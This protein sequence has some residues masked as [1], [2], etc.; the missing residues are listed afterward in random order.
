MSNGLLSVSDII[1]KIQ[2]N[3]ESFT[4]KNHQVM[5]NWCQNVWESWEKL[6]QIPL[7]L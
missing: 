7:C 6:G 1:R 3:F 2:I 4:L 5:S